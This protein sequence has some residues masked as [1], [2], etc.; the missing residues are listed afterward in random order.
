M[1]CKRPTVREFIEQRPNETFYMMTPGGYVYLTPEKA[2]LLLS[3]QSIKGNPGCSGY[4]REIPA[5]ELLNQEVCDANFSK[6]AWHLL[7]DYI[8]ELKQE[9]SPFKQG[10]SLC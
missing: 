3:G 10:V 7:S 4:D 5:E 8:R 9:Q 6:G 2:R 1:S